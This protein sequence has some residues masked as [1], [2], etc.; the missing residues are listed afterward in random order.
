MP[1]GRNPSGNE[2]FIT[3][4]DKVAGKVTLNVETHGKKS[5]KDSVMCGVG[6]GL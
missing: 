2:K 6:G 4:S 3:V 1:R 5:Y